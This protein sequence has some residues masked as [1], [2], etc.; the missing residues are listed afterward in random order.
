MSGNLLFIIIIFI[1]I[2]SLIINQSLIITNHHYYPSGKF[3]HF[4]TH[5][6][7]LKSS[8][9]HTGSIEAMLKRDHP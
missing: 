3:T 1:I 8:E 4:Q 9:D 7:G 2:M 5:F 6:S